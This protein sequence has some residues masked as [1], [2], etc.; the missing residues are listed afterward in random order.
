MTGF[1]GGAQHLVDKALAAAT[2][3]DASQPNV[4]L[5]IVALHES[6]PPGVSEWAVPERGLKNR[7]LLSRAARE[8]TDAPARGQAMSIAWPPPGARLLSRRP[9][10]VLLCSHVAPSPAPNRSPSR[11]ER[12]L[13]SL[14]SPLRCTVH[15]RT[16][17]M[18]N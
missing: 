13:Q 17:G 3:V 11:D 1:L 16:V 12:S 8:P 10:S 18:R 7:I 2:I 9:R 14:R 15:E 6:G 5:V 4:E